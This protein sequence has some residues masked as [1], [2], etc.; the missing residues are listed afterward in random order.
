MK[1]YILRAEWNNLVMANYMVPKELLL[2][3]LPA[4]TEL[5][6][7]EDNCYIS[8]VGFM[9]LNTKMMGL[10]IPF[11][12]NFEEVTLRFYVTYNDHGYKKKGIVF[13]KEIVP[14]YAISF[15]ANNVYKQ[16]F[17][18]MKMRHF[19]QDKGDSFE[20]GYEWKYKDKWNKLSAAASKKSMPLIIGSHAEFIADRY[21]GYTKYN[22]AKTYEYEVAH[23]RWEIFN[24]TGHTVD[25]DF[26]ALYGEE[27]SLLNETELESV[28]MVKG[29]E[30]R[31]HQKK[32]L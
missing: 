26:G 7:F 23:P 20:A 22:A 11:H 8:F 14:K 5:D 4:K 3:Y 31:V 29:S 24:V 10:N 16:D 1:T 15:I 17:T 30:I 21:W 12:T 25:C 27:F 19:H 9:F 28:F 32:L 13:I 6:L 2:P 18:T